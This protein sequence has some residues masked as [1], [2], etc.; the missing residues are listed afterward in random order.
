VLTGL[1]TVTA[2]N[3]ATI[4][5]Q[6]TGLPINVDFQ[7]GQFVKKGDLLAKIDPRTSQVTAATHVL[8]D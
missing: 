1:G 5:S 4:C 3:T 8:F 2:L 6:I 7:E